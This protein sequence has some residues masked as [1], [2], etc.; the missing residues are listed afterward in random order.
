MKDVE[1]RWPAY[2]QNNT[3]TFT[4]D[5]MLDVNYGALDHCN[6]YFQTS[7]FILFEILQ[8]YALF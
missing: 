5:R 3:G 7:I 4:L 2:D 6:C 8:I 1:K